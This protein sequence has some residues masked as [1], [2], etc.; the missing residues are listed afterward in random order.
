[1]PIITIT[2]EDLL[3]SKVVTPGW[4]ACKV[5]NVTE[6]PAKTDGSLNY[7]IDMVITQDGPF[8]GVPLRRVFSE[9]AV[10]FAEHF[11]EAFLGKKIDENG[12]QFELANAVGRSL[13]VFV[14]NGKVENRLVNQA[15]DFAPLGTYSG[16]K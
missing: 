4:Y 13:D 11:I 16:R 5:T 12:G 9:K 6:S 10:G 3:R 2:R 14:K 15:E 1:M 8:N 7:N